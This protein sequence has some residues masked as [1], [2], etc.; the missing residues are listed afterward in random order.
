MRNARRKPAAQLEVNSK[1]SLNAELGADRA[2]GAH[3]AR[4]EAREFSYIVGGE[5][6]RQEHVTVEFTKKKG[7]RWLGADAAI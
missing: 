5:N 2:V 3:R 6:D 1:W 4:R 7:T